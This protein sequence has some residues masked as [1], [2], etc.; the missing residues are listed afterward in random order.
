MRIASGSK[1]EAV[2]HRRQGGRALGPVRVGGEVDEQRHAMAHHQRLELRQGR[3]QRRRRGD[4]PIAGAAFIEGEHRE[5]VSGELLE[6]LRGEQR[7]QL[8]PRRGEE[9][10]RREPNV[11]ARC[12]GAV[13]GCGRPVGRGQQCND[14]R[15]ARTRAQHRITQRWVAVRGLASL[16][17]GLLVQSGPQH[18][19]ALEQT[20]RSIHLGG[21]GRDDHLRGPLLGRVKPAV[22]IS[23]HHLEGWV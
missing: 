7:Q 8:R 14:C 13:R 19:G 12:K 4:D 10:C 15:L 11:C 22:P 21:S 2:H 1:E 5:L 3:V 23:T 18:V 9:R 20:V 17:G 16:F 6:A